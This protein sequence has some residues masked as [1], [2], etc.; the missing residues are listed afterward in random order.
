MSSFIGAQ[1]L[2]PG[3]EETAMAL[4]FDLR[5]PIEKLDTKN[6]Q[7]KAMHCIAVGSIVSSFTFIL[8]LVIGV[9]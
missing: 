8:A 5:R 1:R 6:I 9:L 4:A 3:T 7:S 2:D